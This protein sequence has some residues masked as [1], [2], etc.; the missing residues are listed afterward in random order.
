M[1]LVRESSKLR[2]AID[3]VIGPENG[4]SSSERSNR[5]D[6]AEEKRTITSGLCSPIGR[7]PRAFPSTRVLFVW[8]FSDA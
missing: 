3:R 4:L 7:V 5:G 6:R 2:A 8:S 1:R